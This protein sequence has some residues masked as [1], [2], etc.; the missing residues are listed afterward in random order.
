[1][2]AISHADYVKHDALGLAEL[3]RRKAVSPGELLDAAI[4]RLDAV[5]PKINA[6]AHRF[7]DI[8]KA[9]LE[10]FARSHGAANRPVEIALA[11]DKH[12]HR[13]R[14]AGRP[15]GSGIGSQKRN[16]DQVLNSR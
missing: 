12:H 2:A 14:K 9:W 1:M 4:A 8:A 3:V 6:Q 13:G 11:E 10:P 16:R 7:V 15:P 5:N